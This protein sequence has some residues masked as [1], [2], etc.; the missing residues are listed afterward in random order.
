MTTVTDM[1]SAK[2]FVDIRLKGLKKIENL[3]P[4]LSE[5][6]RREIL[7]GLEKDRYDLQNIIRRAKEGKCAPTFT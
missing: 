1:E 3:I 5:R 4:S 6:D 7:E 2:H